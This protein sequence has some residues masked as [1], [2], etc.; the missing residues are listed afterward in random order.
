MRKLFAALTVFA[1]VL[2]ACEDG[3]EENEST[4]KTTLTINNMSSYNL[5]YDICPSVIDKII[6]F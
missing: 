5:L 2:S 3:G 1:M 4:S 6:N